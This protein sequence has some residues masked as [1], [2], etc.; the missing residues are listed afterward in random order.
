M[1]R[2]FQ[3]LSI[4]ILLVI[5]IS[6]TQAQWVQ[7]ALPG[8]SL[9]AMTFLTNGSLLYAGTNNGIY[10][11]RDSSKTW[12]AAMTGLTSTYVMSLGV[13]GT[14]LFAGTSLSSP[15]VFASSDSGATWSNVSSSA[16]TTSVYALASIGTDMFAGTYGSGVYHST[17]YGASWTAANTGLGNLF[18]W[19]FTVSGQGLYAGTYGSGIFRS[20]DKGTSWTA[21]AGSGLT[22]ANIT[23]LMV[24][25]S[26]IIAGTWD[27][28][29][30]SSSDSGAHFT[31]RNNGLTNMNINA[32]IMI[33]KN[34][35]GNYL[36]AGGA[37]GVFLSPD[38]GTTWNG[39]NTGF[40]MS[41]IYVSA[42]AVSGNYLLAGTTTPVNH[43]GLWR[44]SLSDVITKVQQPADELPVNFM[45]SQNYP[46][47]F[48]PA[49]TFSFSIP[50][51]SFVL[52]KIY[53]LLGREVATIVSEE[54]SAGSYS[55]QWDAAK[56]SSG[57]YFYRLQAG[58]YTQ[59][60]KLVLLR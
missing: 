5:Y 53:D 46:N 55:R 45:L 57:V 30:F 19:C 11:T 4:T 38:S 17:N 39:I 40:D 49:T 15:Y 60:K 7:T 54:M 2:L 10:V 29:V 18:V 58:S 47:P 36:A 43:I 23:T 52:L 21:L 59:T 24:N 25:G 48:N 50:S 44:R 9:G 16:V 35:G 31:A 34:G 51:R 28:G 33:P 1:K 3:I 37:G 6:S 41:K 56:M 8:S 26:K 42:L 12:Q 14:T 22:T 27:G 13:S 20:T 32:L